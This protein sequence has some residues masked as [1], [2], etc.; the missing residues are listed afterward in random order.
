MVLSF[1]SE[2][3]KKKKIVSKE[4]HFSFQNFSLD[5][6]NTI[7]DNIKLNDRNIV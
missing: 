4:I 3:K 5:F 2:F 7:V 1:S 6:E